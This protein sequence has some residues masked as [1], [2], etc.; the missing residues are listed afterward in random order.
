MPSA[1]KTAE[2]IALLDAIGFPPIAPEPPI[3]S[4]ADYLQ[5]DIGSGDLF[6]DTYGDQ[7]KYITDA[8][9]WTI[10]TGMAWKIGAQA[11]VVELAKELTSQKMPAMA[12]DIA[13]D[14]QRM[15][16][17]KWCGKMQSNKARDEMLKSASTKT[18]ITANMSDFDTNIRY[19]NLQNGILDLEALKF[20]SHDR[21][22]TLSKIANTEYNPQAKC[23][24]WERFILEIM[25]GD[26]ALAQ[27]LQKAVGYSLTGNP[28]ED[29]LFIL[30]GAATRN[31]KS[32]LCRSILNVLGDY[33]KSAVPET[34]ATNRFK[35]GSSTSPDLARLKGARFV[36]MPE[37]SKGLELDGSLVKQLTGRD[38][39]VTRNL[40]QGF[41][42]YI[43][44]FVIWM[45]SNYRPLINDM[46]LFTS[47]R[48]FTIPFEVNFQAE[49]QEKNLLEQFAQPEAKSAILN[50]ILEGLILYRQEGLRDNVPEAIAASTQE[51]ADDSDTFGT[52]LRECVMP[53]E[54]DFTLTKDIYREYEQWAGD[55][56]YRPMS[57]KS[58][59]G[60]M[61][62]R[63]YKD[64]RK[65]TGAGFMDIVL[66][67]DLPD[68]WR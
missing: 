46:T 10:Y 68:G 42:E 8:Q 66:S 67:K 39:I 2:K 64:K 9:Q 3:K 27:F 28:V 41:F 54:N 30:Y 33:G 17:L 57:M 65:N 37:P 16:W 60:E 43:P 26:K 62:R 5:N 59:V 35:S 1:L 52:F 63:G 47:G 40:Y 12:Q 20:L 48:I 25:N 7:V 49:R 13:D 51:Y 44:Q 23:E 21:K 32:T 61:K 22:L 36:N 6:N 4:A 18:G 34:L 29:C 11:E 31:G 15:A 53:C 38:P 50:W 14:T 45:N 56:G 55:G 19:L 24:R 58:L